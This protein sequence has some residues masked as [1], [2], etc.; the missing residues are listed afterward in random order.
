MRAGGG[1]SATNAT[2]M[3]LLDSIFDS[4]YASNGGGVFVQ[5]CGSSIFAG[6][7]FYDNQVTHSGGGL[8]LLNCSGTA[9]GTSARCKTI[10]DFWVLP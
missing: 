6:N 4:N 3:A 7:T 9:L 8:F 5:G 10:L 2:T 1:I